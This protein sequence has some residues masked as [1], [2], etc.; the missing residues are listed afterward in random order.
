MKRYGCSLLRDLRL[1]NQA[2]IMVCALVGLI[3]HSCNVNVKAEKGRE[4][5]S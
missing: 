5:V 1:F 4:I 3:Y 2:K